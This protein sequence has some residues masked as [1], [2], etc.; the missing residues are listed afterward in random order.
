[1]NI[2]TTQPRC[3]SCCA[4]LT[5]DDYRE[6]KFS[7]SRARGWSELALLPRRDPGRS[8]RRPDRAHWPRDTRQVKKVKNVTGRV[9]PSY[10]RVHCGANMHIFN[11]SEGNVYVEVVD[12]TGELRV[13]PP[14]HGDV[15]LVI[16][17]GKDH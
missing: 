13:K 2:W 1:M 8:I 15:T 16:K 12:D 6:H 3:S 14:K 4:R 11:G 10:S 9:I 5:F 17:F 7:C